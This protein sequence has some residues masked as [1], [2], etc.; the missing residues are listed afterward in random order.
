MTAPHNGLRGLYSFRTFSPLILTGGKGR[1][2]KGPY[3]YGASH[4]TIPYSGFGRS[5]DT[6]PRWPMRTKK[7]RKRGRGVPQCGG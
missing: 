5:S 3:P 2:G 4:G 7:K 6:P 1:S